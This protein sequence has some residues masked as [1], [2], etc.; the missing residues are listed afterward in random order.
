MNL[1]RFRRR[2]FVRVAW[3]FFYV[4]SAAALFAFMES[5]RRKK[6]EK[7]EANM[8][9]LKLE[10]FFSFS[11][12]K[13]FI[14]DKSG[15]KFSGQARDGA[16][17][18][19]E[20]EGKKTFKR[21]LENEID[22]HSLAR[23]FFCAMMRRWKVRDIDTWGPTTRQPAVALGEMTRT[24]KFFARVSRPPTRKSEFFP[25]HCDSRGRFFRIFPPRKKFLSA[26]MCACFYGGRE[27]FAAHVL[28][29]MIKR[30]FF[31]SS[32]NTSIQ[33]TLW[34]FKALPRVSLTRLTLI[35]HLPAPLSRLEQNLLPLRRAITA[36]ICLQTQRRNLFA[37]LR[38]KLCLPRR[39]FLSCLINFHQHTIKIVGSTP[40]I[41]A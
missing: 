16:A 37:L 5:R 1:N 8:L 40:C 36:G 25:P 32:F 22:L 14:I 28:V 26:R 21:S 27:T 3:D 4:F 31:I 13:C 41:R 11:G 17:L 6:R 34:S 19:V 35:P 2:H 9:V 10:T 29:R 15:E 23:S 38:C 18:I 24:I 20:G 39:E 12:Y 33:G 7:K 30:V